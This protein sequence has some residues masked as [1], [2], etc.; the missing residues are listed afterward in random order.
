MLREELVAYLDD[1]LAIREIPD[2]KDAFNGLQAEGRGEVKR[3]AVAVDACLATLERAV[4]ESADMLIVHH[5]LFWGA[6][7]PV[8][9]PYHRRLAL[10]LKNDLNV[11]S[12]HLPLD[13]HP[14]VGN[15]HVLARLLGLEPAGTFGEFEGTPIG[16]FAEIEITRDAFVQRV[17]DVLG[18]TPLTIATGPDIVRRV[19]I[20]TGG[21][22][23]WI[24]RAAR[25][26]LDTFLTGEG[27]HHTYFDA[28]ELGLNV[29]YAGHYAT[30][31]V[32][33]RALG[34]HLSQ[35]FHLETFFL[36]HPTGL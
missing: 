32:G 3:V 18:I 20:A 31:T 9:G 29:L 27:P 26:G 28:E 33:V 35:R 2:Y 4:Q 8:V 11:Y 23:T 14:E 1:Y 13:A 7:A 19:G 36:D 30:E 10:I 16:V 12:C 5:G 15:N 21:A 34:A 6:K 24:E 25:K 17:R 22:G